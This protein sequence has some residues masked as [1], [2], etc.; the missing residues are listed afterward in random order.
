MKP[1]VKAKELMRRRR[2]AVAAVDEAESFFKGA[3]VYLSE[4][5]KVSAGYYVPRHDREGPP[6]PY[7]RLKSASG[8]RYSS[9]PNIDEAVTLEQC[10]RLVELRHHFDR[11][12]AGE[13]GRPL[14]GD[15][16][17]GD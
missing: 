15:E 10:K 3:V 4:G 11:Y 1:E 16:S 12:L 14:P 8:D 6:G 7:F 9:R 17:D 2:E 5:L 13:E